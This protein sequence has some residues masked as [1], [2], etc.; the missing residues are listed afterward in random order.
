MFCFQKKKI[1]KYD[2]C[3]FRKSNA[4]NGKFPQLET[5]Q[6]QQQKNNEKKHI[7]KQNFMESILA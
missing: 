7:N 2:F 5:Q 3:F 6:Q 1:E 4:A